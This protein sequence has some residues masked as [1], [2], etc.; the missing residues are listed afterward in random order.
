MRGG[1]TLSGI[2]FS[3]VSMPSSVHKAL[4]LPTAPLGTVYWVSDASFKCPNCR[5]LDHLIPVTVGFYCCKNRYRGTK[6]T[7]NKYAS[8]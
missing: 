6:A 4:F 8:D 1:H 3:D 7:G 2:S 5:R